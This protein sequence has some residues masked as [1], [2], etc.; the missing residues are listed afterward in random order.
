MAFR[1]S[2]KLCILATFNFGLNFLLSDLAG[3][4]ERSEDIGREHW[5]KNTQSNNRKT[6]F[7]L[8]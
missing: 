1:L 8:D 4:S 2:T 3:T 7:W 5:K 6:W